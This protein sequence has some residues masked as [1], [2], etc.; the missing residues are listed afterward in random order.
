MRAGDVHVELLERGQ[1][2]R[3]AVRV[4]DGG[5]GRMRDDYLLDD[6]LFRPVRS[7]GQPS[8]P[9]CSPAVR[10]EHEPTCGRDWRALL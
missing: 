1:R 9:P 8:P 7:T 5:C 10:A 3:A 6:Y 4:A 2:L